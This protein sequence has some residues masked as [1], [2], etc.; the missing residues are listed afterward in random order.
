MK[1]VVLTEYNKK[2][3]LY[4]NGFRNTGSIC[5]FN[6]VLQSMLSCTSFINELMNQT[7]TSKNPVVNVLIDFIKESKNYQT[8]VQNLATIEIITCAKNKLCDYAANIRKQM[9]VTLCEKKNMRISDFMQGQQCAGELFHY[10]LESME[11]F[12]SIQNLFS[13]R[14][15]SLIRCDTCDK[16]VSD[17]NCTYSLFEVD[18]SLKVEQLDQFNQYNVT[19]KNMNEFLYK[20]TSY[21]DKFYKCPECKTGGE[22]YKLTVLTMIPEI[23]VVMSKKFKTGAC[24]NIHTEFPN[25]LE[26][27]NTCGGTMVY[28]AVSQ[29]DHSGDMNSGHY[30]ATCRRKT[31]WFVIN[32]MQVSPSQF[33][34][35][36][37]TYI[38]FYHIMKKK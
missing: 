27:N 23:L 29:I 17:V 20:Q 31:G 15:K 7:H 38:V 1:G 4:P 28:E 36:K 25:T 16:W 9:L 37:D 26:F 19:P 14:Y 34:P 10:L 3:E 30:W 21:V 24:I 18:P 13:H 8:L 6:T 5:Y 11:E 12:Q 2:M 33:N 22:R 35:T 32:D